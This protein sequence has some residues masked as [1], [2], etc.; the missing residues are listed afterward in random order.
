MSGGII[1]KHVNCCGMALR[2]ELLQLHVQVIS[3]AFAGVET[4][5]YLKHVSLLYNWTL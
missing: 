1:C 5:L 3:A 4:T 2:N